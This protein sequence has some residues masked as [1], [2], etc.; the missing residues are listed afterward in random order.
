[1]DH[2]LIAIFEQALALL[3]QNR[4]DELK[5]L[6]Q[7][8]HP[9]DLAEVLE[10]L[11][12][13]QQTLILRLLS[14]EA[15][16]DT[17][18]E[19]EAEDQVSILESLGDERAGDIL[20]EM[21]DDDVADLVGE[22]S[23]EQAADLLNLMDAEGSA[24]VRE[25]LEFGPETAGGI[26][27]TEYV[28]LGAD[29]TAQMAIDE[30]RR[31][32]PGAETAY[33]VYV[34]NEHEK[35]LGV[36]SL[37][38]LIVSPPER[39]IREI[40]RRSVQTVQVDE[41]QEEVARV[42]KKYNLLAVP[43]VDHYNVL[44]GIVTVDDVI[45]VLEDEATEDIYRAAGVGGEAAQD[46]ADGIWPAIRARL[47]WLV[48]LLF[49]EMVS[50]LV[51][52]HFSGIITTFAVLSIFITTMSGEAGNAA[53]QSLTVVVRGLATGE[54]DRSQIWAIVWR[55]LR[56]GVVIGA[57]CGVVLAV[58]AAMWQRSVWIGLIAGSSIF[59]NMIIA[60]AAGAFFPVIIDRFGIDPAV[61]SGPLITT[62]TDSTSMLIYFGIAS[63][64]LQYVAL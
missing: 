19:M 26:M 49:L 56:V 55:E 40:M 50:G 43:V 53:T 3:E 6:L 12:D 37:R 63:V 21:S 48:S 18:S 57:A 22:L 58:S 41:D 32:A 24:D 7:T 35:L 23:P 17:L 15:A 54:I 29:L 61:A 28:A 11:K 10:E 42:V 8:L 34:V 30:M 44:R 2:D 25:L 60:K 1:M 9:A 46:L 39:P 51:I 33:Y 13:E 4:Q 36:L 14:D 16:A 38:D 31:L 52:D 62:V 27:T 64:V 45:D 5:Q 20:E 59:F 47:P